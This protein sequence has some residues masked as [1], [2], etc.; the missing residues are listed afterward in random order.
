MALHSPIGFSGAKRYLNC[1]GSVKLSEGI[2][3]RESGFAALG[4]AAHAFVEYVLVNKLSPADFKNWWVT[5]DG[6]VIRDKPNSEGAYQIEGE[7]VEAAILVQDYVNSLMIEGDELYVE[8]QF[9]LPDI[10]ELLFGTADVVIYSRSR[11]LL[12]ILD[13]K[14]GAGVL[15]DVIDNEQVIG[16]GIGV[17][18]GTWTG[19][20][21]PIGPVRD[22]RLVIAQPRAFHNADPIR[23]AEAHII[24]FVDW[25]DIFREGIAKVYSDTPEFRIGA[26]CQFCRVAALCPLQIAEVQEKMPEIPQGKYDPQVLADGLAW[27]KLATARIKAVKDFAEAEAVNRGVKI[28]GYKV[29]RSIGD[30]QFTNETEVFAALVTAGYAPE[31]IQS[32]PVPAALKSP[33]QVEAVTGKSK[34]DELLSGYVVRPEGKLTLALE[35]DK[36][37]AVA[38]DARAGFEPVSEVNPF[39]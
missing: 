7:M 24:D 13:F 38:Y 9:S 37:P 39:D 31:E 35:K 15:V 22:V 1:P 21:N 2:A 28:P 34:F 23:E 30:R 27:V 12:I 25:I 33:A 4:T 16:Y 20:D 17:I 3:N 26:W 14:Y 11:K 6:L 19:Q 5:A 8:I 29:V 36:R 18:T 10:H 32:P